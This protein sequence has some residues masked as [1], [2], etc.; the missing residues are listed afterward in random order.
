MIDQSLATLE[1]NQENTEAWAKRFT[2]AITPSDFPEPN[3][4]FEVLND[5][6]SSESKPVDI[7]V[8]RAADSWF[9]KELLATLRSYIRN[10]IEGKEH[11]G[12]TMVS[13]TATTEAL[14]EALCKSMGFEPSSMHERKM[15]LTIPAGHQKL[16]DQINKQLKPSY[17]NLKILPADNMTSNQGAFAML[18][19]DEGVEGKAKIG[20]FTMHNLVKVV[21]KGDETLGPA[22]M[23]AFPDYK[24]DIDHPEQIAVL[25][26]I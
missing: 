12:F 15:T 16:I 2:I 23:L 1:I 20:R 21:S 26:R 6:S 25:T 18:I 9:Q 3:L 19:C 14:V 17:P 4:R 5:L 7:N 24:L 22:F 8:Q 11:R 10:E 13:A